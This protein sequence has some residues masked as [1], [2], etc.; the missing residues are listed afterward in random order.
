MPTIFSHIALPV[1]AAIAAGKARVPTSMLLA[2]ILASIVP[3]FDGIAFKLGIAYGGMW[4]HRGFTHTLG[5]ALAMGLFGLLL[6]RRW[7]LPAWKAYG[8]VALCTFSHP[9]ADTLTNGGIAI[10]LYWPMS[11]TR[12]FSPWRPVEVSPIALKRF[13]SERGTAVI[14]SEIKVLWIPLMSVALVFFAWRNWFARKSAL[15]AL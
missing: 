4:G 11:E 1:C 10:P 9:V 14:W 6:A 7:R 3:D 2:G 12:F 8:W 15:A 5:F 13:F